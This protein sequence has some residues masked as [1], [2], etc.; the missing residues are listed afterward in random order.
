MLFEIFGNKTFVNFCIRFP[1]SSAAQPAESILKFVE[2]WVD[3]TNSDVASEARSRPNPE[4]RLSKQAYQVTQ[5]IKEGQWIHDWV[6]EDRSNG[7]QLSEAEK[8]LWYECTNGHLARKLADIK[9]KQIP[10]HKGAA[11]YIAKSEGKRS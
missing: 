8:T 11:H 4:P 6:K 2:G 7:W 5:S 10:K 9:S 1:L 3:Y